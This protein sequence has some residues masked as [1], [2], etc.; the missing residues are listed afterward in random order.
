MKSSLVSHVLPYA[1]LEYTAT[2]S[3]TGKNEFFA[4]YNLFAGSDTDVSEDTMKYFLPEGFLPG[5][6]VEAEHV[7]PAIKERMFFNP[8]TS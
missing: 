3:T 4:G 7:N 1:F 8:L 6:E 2:G 5:D